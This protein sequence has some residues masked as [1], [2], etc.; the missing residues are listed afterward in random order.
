MADP[1]EISTE[2]LHTHME[3]AA[4]SYVS[5][6]TRLMMRELGVEEDD[7]QTRNRFAIQ[8]VE[9]LNHA[10][11]AAWCALMEDKQGVDRAMEELKKAIDAIP[12]PID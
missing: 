8:M 12:I 3:M 1:S 6:Y 9:P 11:H 2:D 7:A 10:T 4:A 5:L